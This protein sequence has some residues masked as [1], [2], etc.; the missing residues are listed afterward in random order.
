MKKLDNLLWNF[1]VLGILL[2]IIVTVGQ[3]FV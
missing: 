3:R 2:L 1:L